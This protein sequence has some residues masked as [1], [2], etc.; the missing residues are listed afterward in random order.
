M[1]LLLVLVLRMQLR[2]LSLLLLAVRYDCRCRH[3]SNDWSW[4]VEDLLGC[5]AIG[6]ATTA[7]RGTRTR[8]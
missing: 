3:G 6:I 1:V 4:L 5:R 8:G 2:L 7:T